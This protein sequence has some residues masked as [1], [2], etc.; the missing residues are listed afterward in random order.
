M[1]DTYVRTFQLPE[2][3]ACRVSITVLRALPE[4]STQQSLGAHAVPGTRPSRPAFRRPAPSLGVQAATVIQSW[5]AARY[6]CVNAVMRSAYAFPAGAE[7]RIP[8]ELG[9]RDARA[10]GRESETRAKEG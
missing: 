6:E 8:R 3:G 5:P 1:Y 10:E 9:R 2:Q 7:W 4:L